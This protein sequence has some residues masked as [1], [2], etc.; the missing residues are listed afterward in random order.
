[1]RNR[2]FWHFFSAPSLTFWSVFPLSS[3]TVPGLSLPWPYVNIFLPIF[4]ALS[5]IFLTQ[6][7]LPHLPSH[8]GMLW[9]PDLPSG[10]LFYHL[11]FPLQHGSSLDLSPFPLS[12]SFP[13]CPSCSFSSSFSVLHPKTLP[14][15]ALVGRRTASTILTPATCV[16]SFYLLC[17]STH[18]LP[19]S[20]LSVSASSPLAH[21]GRSNY[22]A[23]VLAS[24]SR[25]TGHV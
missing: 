25:N 4:P 20:L 14:N 11:H 18:L 23:K 10:T 21:C 6:S 2:F 15:P 12:I 8:I 19:F 7:I 3:I 16:L 5:I 22:P 13:S 17:P 1:M 24:K 9:A